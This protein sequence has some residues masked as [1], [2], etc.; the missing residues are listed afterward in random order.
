MLDLIPLIL[1]T[2]IAI[3][4]MYK[5]RKLIKENSLL[6]EQI[7]GYSIHSDDSNIIQEQFLKFVSDSREWAFEYI[8]EVQ[9]EM[10]EIVRD[11]NP[12]IAKWEKKKSKTDD[13][14][15]MIIAYNRMIKL[16]PKDE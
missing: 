14:E 12:A 5:S 9:Q 13:Q 7:K 1:I 16:L 8:E 10:S 4:F 11:M 6:K 2:F 3:L 15:Q